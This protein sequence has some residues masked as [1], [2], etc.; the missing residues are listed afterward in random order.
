MTLV[1]VHQPNYAPWLGFFA[2]V[3]AADVFVLL[4]DAPRDRA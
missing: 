2:K 3:A 4:D 1:A